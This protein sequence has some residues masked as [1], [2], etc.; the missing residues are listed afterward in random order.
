MKSLNNST[1]NESAYLNRFYNFEQNI[2]IS[3]R[4]NDPFNDFHQKTDAT[5]N[6]YGLNILTPGAKLQTEN[7]QIPDFRIVCRD[8]FNTFLIYHPPYSALQFLPVFQNLGKVDPVRMKS[9]LKN[10]ETRF[11]L[12]NNE[13]LKVVLIHWKPG[14]VSDIHGHP[15]GGCMFKVLQGKLQEIRYTSDSAQ[16]ITEFN[17]YR[18]EDIAYIDDT[19]GY[20][21]VGNPF[22]SSAV[23]LHAYTPGDKK[24]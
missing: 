22:G 11:E 18:A 15:E 4:S 17:S 1:F 24:L 7:G 20:H 13:F 12:V 10:R 14:K 6:T 3:G 8:L 21:A 23:T 5:S 9:F 19:Q 2:G 16:K